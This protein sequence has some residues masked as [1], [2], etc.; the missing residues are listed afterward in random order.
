[1]SI[2]PL[3]GYDVFTQLIFFAMVNMF[4]MYLF[5]RDIS[6]IPI[7]IIIMIFLN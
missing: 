2:D 6:H 3:A 1:M 4:F 5:T 7:S